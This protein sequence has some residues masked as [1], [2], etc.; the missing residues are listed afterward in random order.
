MVSI[1]IILEHGLIIY[2]SAEVNNDFVTW[3][4]LIWDIHTWSLKCKWNDD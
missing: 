1:I 4:N 3:L 2:W